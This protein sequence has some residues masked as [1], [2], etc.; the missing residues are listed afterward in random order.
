MARR[1][2][3]DQAAMPEQTMEQ[4]ES[5]SGQFATEQQGAQAAMLALEDKTV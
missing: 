1:R 4:P 3:E 5:R 2:N